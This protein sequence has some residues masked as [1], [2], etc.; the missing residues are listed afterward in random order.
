[1]TTDG[2]FIPMQ[3]VD[4]Q[5]NVE[6]LC[7]KLGLRYY[8]TRR[9]EGS[10]T[11]F[12]DLVICL[13]PYQGVLYRELKGHVRKGKRYVVGELTQDQADWL[14]DLRLAGENA[15]LWTPIEWRDGT[16]DRELGAA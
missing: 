16:I 6:S 15:R 8:H 10:A 3:E 11:G 2:T 5:H 13:G 9:S 4:L 7:L 14:H 1:M 12:P